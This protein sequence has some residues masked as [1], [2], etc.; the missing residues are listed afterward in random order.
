M[1]GMGIR[2][3]RMPDIRRLFSK[4]PSGADAIGALLVIVTA[5]HTADACTANKSA[6]LH[7][8]AP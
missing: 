2:L 3:D 4:D 6:T 1:I 8:C 5:H 7:C